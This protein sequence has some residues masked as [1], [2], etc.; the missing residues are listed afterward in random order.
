MLAKRFGESAGMWL[1]GILGGLVSSTAV[2]IASGRK[3]EQGPQA[4]AFGLQATLLAGAVLYPRLL[5]IIAFV[6]PEFAWPLAW[7]FAILG[8]IGLL[9]G[10]DGKDAAA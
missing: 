6:N 5:V 4:G 8:V 10:G 3:A 9:L 2:A 7:R 1:S